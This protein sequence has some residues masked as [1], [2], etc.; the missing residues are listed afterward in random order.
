V[1]GVDAHAVEVEVN[2]NYGKMVTVVV[3]LPD[4]AVKESYHRVI[5]E[6]NNSAFRPVELAKSP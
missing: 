3:G 6:V 5:T 1:W 4:T 2:A